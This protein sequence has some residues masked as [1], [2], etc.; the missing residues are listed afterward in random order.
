M[1]ITATGNFRLLIKSGIAT[2]SACLFQ[3]EKIIQDNEKARGNQEYTAFLKLYKAYNRLLNEFNAV[4]S[5]LLIL[6]YMIDYEA[7]RYCR[8]KGYAISLDNSA[9]YAD[10]I[11]KAMR[12][13]DNLITKLTLKKN[14]LLK[15]QRGEGGGKMQSFESL[16]ANMSFELGYTLPD[17]ITLARFNEY[18]K[19]MER[20]HKA[21]KAQRESYGRRT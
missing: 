6:C 12:K 1:T 7:V 11:A 2:A 9:A 8:S 3:W 10:S 5:H 17:N 16:M 19:I 20:Q 14:E 15:M 21:E 18:V 4:K 13:S